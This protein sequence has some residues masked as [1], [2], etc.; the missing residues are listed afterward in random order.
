MGS[1]CQTPLAHVNGCYW[2][3]ARLLKA[4]PYMAVRRVAPGSCAAAT[5]TLADFFLRLDSRHPAA[6]AAAAAAT[7]PRK[8]CSFKCALSNARE[9]KRTPH[10]IVHMMTIYR[11]REVKLRVR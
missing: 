4:L 5:F 1:T 3:A 10:I 9:Q 8:S 6:A 7:W 11:A 2:Q